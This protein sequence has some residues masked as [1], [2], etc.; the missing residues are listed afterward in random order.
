VESG[1]Y[2]KI[3]G[4]VLEVNNEG[5]IV[6]TGE[7]CLSV[8]ELQLEGKRRMD[9]AEFIRGHKIEKGMVLGS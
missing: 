6:A 4:T 2:P 3:P 8:K 9:V 1:Q 7:G 5:I